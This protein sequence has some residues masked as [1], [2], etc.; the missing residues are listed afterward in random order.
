MS[1]TVKLYRLS[2]AQRA[3]LYEVIE[4]FGL[5]VSTFF[6]E[7]KCRVEFFAEPTEDGIGYNKATRDCKAALMAI[8]GGKDVDDWTAVKE[9]SPHSGG[10]AFKDGYRHIIAVDIKR[11]PFP[12]L[13]QYGKEI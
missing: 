11:E 2:H 9:P 4:A 10:K 13:A 1:G 6:S 3:A 7:S 12:M 8:C 5:E